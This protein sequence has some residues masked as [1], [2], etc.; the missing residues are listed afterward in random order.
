MKNSQPGMWSIA[1]SALLLFTSCY[2]LYRWETRP[3][4]VLDVYQLG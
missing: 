4:T 3:K 2:I 1:P